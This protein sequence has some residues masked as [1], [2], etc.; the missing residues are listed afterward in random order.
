MDGRWRIRTRHESCSERNWK[1]N[2]GARVWKWQIQEQTNVW[3]SASGRTGLLQMSSGLTQKARFALSSAAVCKAEENKGVWVVEFSRGMLARLQQ[4]ATKRKMSFC[5]Q[6][7]LLF[8]PQFFFFFDLQGFRRWHSLFALYHH[9]MPWQQLFWNAVVV[10][11]AW[12]SLITK[13]CRLQ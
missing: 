9:S 2:K 3:L 7:W 12:L 13:L 4:C 5:P 1:V 8:S 6:G 10:L 11:Q